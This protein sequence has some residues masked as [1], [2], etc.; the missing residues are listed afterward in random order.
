[1]VLKVGVCMYRVGERTV[2]W[3]Y[4]VWDVARRDGVTSMKYAG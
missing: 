3:R 4:G 1:M 2:E